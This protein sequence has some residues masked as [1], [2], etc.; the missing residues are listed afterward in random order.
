M[1]FRN[2]FCGALVIYIIGSFSIMLFFIDRVVIFVTGNRLFPA[3][4]QDFSYFSRDYFWVI[5]GFLLIGATFLIRPFEK[6]L[7]NKPKMILSKLTLA[8]WAILPLMRLKPH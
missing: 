1:K 6:Y 7:L 2:L 5:F 8:S 4:S 3:Y